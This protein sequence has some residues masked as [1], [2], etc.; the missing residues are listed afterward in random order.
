MPEVSQNRSALR[1]G[2]AVAAGLAL[3]VYINSL[4]NGFMADDGQAIAFSAVAGPPSNWRA[5]LVTPAAVVLRG[6]TT[7]TYAPLTAWIFTVGHAMGDPPLLHHLF[8]IVCHI[9]TSALLV[10]LVAATGLPALAAGLAGALFAVHPIHTETV[11]HIASRGALLSGMF[12]V[13]ALLLWRRQRSLVGGFAAVVVSALAL[14]ASEQALAVLLL[15]PLADALG[16][17]TAPR[18][19]RGSRVVLYAALLAI[20]A[21]YLMLRRAAYHS[22][23]APDQAALFQ[24]NPAALLSPGLRIVTGLKTTALAVSKL[25]APVRLSADYSYRQLVGVQSLAEPGALVGLFT[26]IAIAMLASALWARHRTAF[27]WTLFAVLTYGVVSNIPFTADAIFREDVLYL[28]SAGVCALV[29]LAIGALADA[30]SRELG[31]VV[32]AILV[33][34]A[35]TLTVM[36]NP[37]WYDELRLAEATAAT[38]PDSARAHRLLGTAYSDANRA[39]DAIREFGRALG[40]Y[41]GD[42][43]SLYNVGVILQRQDKRLEALT[44]F[45]RVTDL[46]PKYVPAWINIAAINNAET[47][48]KPALD[49]AERAIAVRSDIP[50]AW[51]VKGHALRGMSKLPE[52]RAAFEE[53]LRLAPGQPRALLGLGATTIDLQDWTA[54]ASV[55]ERLIK[56]APVPD[57][58]R[59]LV[60][61]YRQGGH[62]TEAA[63]V[64]ATAHQMFPNDEFFAPEPPQAQ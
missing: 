10:P 29:A 27:F 31:A 32:A 18:R 64:A 17:G 13:L 14:L 56:I 49:A 28:P 22:V 43:A 33:V 38:A 63:N 60:F 6:G 44:V 1:A 54:S 7:G 35:G 34:A 25:F 47:A 26:G 2:S 50:N 52:A 57:A 11:D 21:G 37:V 36:R 62:E 40:I 5:F 41:P 30:R 46:D 48:F 15:L 51:V 24:G 39:D 53:A 3:I 61:S 16:D 58:Y 45:R 42:K 12:V 19:E 20:G 59:G 23:G 55:F 9:A 8:N 4:P